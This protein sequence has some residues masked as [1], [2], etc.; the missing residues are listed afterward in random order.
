MD[1]KFT[2]LNRRLPRQ[3]QL[4]QGS[5]PTQDTLRASTSTTSLERKARQYS[6]VTEVQ[7]LCL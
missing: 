7:V 2:F 5:A 3:Q 1:V 6:T 4:R